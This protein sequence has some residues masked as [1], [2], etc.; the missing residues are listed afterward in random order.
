[1]AN[2]S[3]STASELA[4]SW[5]TGA[6]FFC[7]LGGLVSVGAGIS[8]VVIEAAGQNSLLEAIAH[9]MGW[10]FIGKGL[11]MTAVA[12]QVKSAVNHLFSK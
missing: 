1:M 6:R 11:F 7:G 5:G 9:G 10:Y 2:E 3:T 8:L 4:H 12:F